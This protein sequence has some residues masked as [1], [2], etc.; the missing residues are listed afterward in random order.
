[1]QHNHQI[2]YEFRNELS[3]TKIASTI[4]QTEAYTSKRITEANGKY[5]GVVA[6]PAGIEPATPSLEVSAKW[7]L[8]ALIQVE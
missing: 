8:L 1:M 2:Y 5:A 3:K 6:C 7:H 4:N